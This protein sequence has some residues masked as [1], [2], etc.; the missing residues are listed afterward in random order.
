M[1]DA[2]TKQNNS[3]AGAGFGSEE[4]TGMQNLS[5]GR[6]LS[7][8]SERHDERARSGREEAIIVMMFNDN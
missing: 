7:I 2:H 6:W 4:W 8:C 1:Y 3:T 5:Q